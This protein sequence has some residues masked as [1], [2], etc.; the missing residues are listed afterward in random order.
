MNDTSVRI[1]I[2]EDEVLIAMHLARQLEDAGFELCDPVTNG[3]AALETAELERPDVV[4][5]DV[6]L[7]GDM[8]GVDTGRAIRDRYGIPIVFLTGYSDPNV[9]SR[10]REITAAEILGKPASVRQITA[11]IGQVLG[12]EA[13]G[14]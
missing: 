2:V 1:L 7:A 11:A 8:D 6:R 3:N 9:E 12:Q 13:G 4:L 14:D 10:A 5:L